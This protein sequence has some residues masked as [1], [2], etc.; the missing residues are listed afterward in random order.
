MEQQ[1]T[2]EDVPFLQDL[3]SLTLSSPV[4]V[5]P[6]LFNQ[7]TPGAHFIINQQRYDVA[8]D[9]A[10]TPLSCIDL[11]VADKLGLEIQPQQGIITLE[12]WA[13]KV[14]KL[15]PVFWPRCAFFP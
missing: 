14:A 7:I 15:L 5:H 9:T 2:Q 12:S 11:S 3:A 10:C 13:F 4:D 6:S 1:E 8:L